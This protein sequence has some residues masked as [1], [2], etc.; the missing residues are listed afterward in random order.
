MREFIEAIVGEEKLNFRYKDYN[1][2]FVKQDYDS[3]Y[4]FYFLD[5]R[6]QLITLQK[7]AVEIFS[8]IK[9]DKELYKPDMD[10]NTT[11]IFFLHV[12]EQEYYE[13][14]ENGEISELSKI[15]CLV[16]E[17]LNY[18]KKN[19][20]LY[21]DNMEKFAQRNKGKFESICDEYFT[22]HYFERYK[23]SCR[24][25]FE[26]DFLINLFI[27]IP[28]LS[29]YGYQPVEQKV[30]QT[31]EA[32][33]KQKCREAEINQNYIE[34]ISD[35]IESLDNEQELF[36]WVDVLLQEDLKEGTVEDEN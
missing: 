5:D 35:K 22:E 2:L 28:F 7:E 16:E 26:Y 33:I 25:S 36:E 20:F 9:G 29:F 3:Y 8:S 23:E 30:Y 13:I 32:F 18:F 34:K 6:S 27:K 1:S 4:L 21:T 31:M 15:I 12:T 19:V 11:C 17:D 14:G 24:N 10:K